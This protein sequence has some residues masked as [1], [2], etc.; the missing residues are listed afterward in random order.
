[1]K[2]TKIEQQ[3]KITAYVLENDNGV[4]VRI[5]IMG[6][7]VQRVELPDSE[8]GKVNVCLN[9]ED[10]SVYGGNSLFAGATVAPVAGRIAG[11]R[12]A[13]GNKI[14]PLVPN[15]SGSC[16]HG[17][18]VNGSFLEWTV[19]Q[20]CATEEEAKVGL[21]LILPEDLEGFPGNR[22]FTATYKLDNGNRL[23]VDYTAVTDRD[24]Y[25][26][27]TNHSYFNLSGDFTRSGLEQKLQL[28]SS[29]YMVSNENNLSIGLAPV[30][31]TPFD[32]R[33]G[34]IMREALEAY[35]GNAQVEKAKG[36]DHAFDVREAAAAGE[37][38]AELS[39]PVSG[40][41]VK[42]SSTTGRCMVVY[43]GGYIGDGFTLAGGVTSSDGCA[44]ALEC[45]SFPNAVNMPEME[46]RILRE[47][48]SYRHRIVYEFGF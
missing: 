12:F 21:T 7:A 45:Q 16:L 9:F 42:I 25:V 39:D 4:A 48:E 47:G 17:G 8:G 13:I 33:E 23:T 15:D 5:G 1:M 3:G 11:S 37:V 35:P 22:I 43:T 24:T 38:L 34:K 31:G 28:A 18:K 19:L 26:D 2:I 46:P 20:A 29:A 40:R 32:F 6:A 44:V 27:M 30:E 36:V 41:S 10:L 14:Y